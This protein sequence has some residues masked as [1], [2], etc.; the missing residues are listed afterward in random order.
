MVYGVW[1]MVYGVRMVWCMCMYKSG[2]F[3]PASHAYH[4]DKAYYDTDLVIFDIHDHFVAWL[5]TLV[6]SKYEYIEYASSR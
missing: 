3:L 5:V 1:C 6:T 4:V 2:Y